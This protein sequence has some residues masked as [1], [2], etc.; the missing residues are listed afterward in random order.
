MIR[1]TLRRGLG[2]A[3]GLLLNAATGVAALLL[4]A[5]MLVSAALVPVAGI[6]LWLLARVLTPVRSLARFQR[7]WAGRTLGRGITEPYRSPAGPGIRA[8]LIPCLRDPATW[9]DLAWLAVHGVTSALFTI[10]VWA[11][12]SAID[13][14][15]YLPVTRTGS[16]V[17]V[18][19]SL[20][21]TAIVAVTL[22]AVPL[23]R[24][25]QARLACLLL[26]PGFSAAERIRQL[27]ESRAATIGAQ[28]AELRR[29]ER[30]LHDG[31][32]A[33]LVSIR[34]NLGLA[35]GNRD[36]V[37]IQELVEEAWESVGQ[38]LTDLRD[39]V[40]GIHPPVLADRGLSGAIEAAA[41]LCPV[42]VE[43][44]IDLPGRPEAPVE[45]AAYFAAGEALTNMAK[46]SGATRAWV[47]LRHSGDV[48]RLTVGDDGRGG[49]D[50][51]AGT[52]IRGIERRLSAFDGSLTVSSP[53]GGPTELTME[54]PCALSSPKI[55]PSYATA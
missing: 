19:L 48:L 16:S 40:R 33:R 24:A 18:A 26:R 38:A 25:G 4:I 35:R 21:I 36:P 31:A 2:S 9:R 3:G 52:G 23:F 28:A 49:A 32:Q 54:L 55:S 17:S 44:E 20:A 41:L 53:V 29:I 30:D 1:R 11:M 14:I 45:S 43:I 51:S 34:M 12:W 37:Q 47:R 8:H 15:L 50:P 46:H 42:P 22:M 27:T 10:A 5:L 7:A 13:L 39:L 6:G